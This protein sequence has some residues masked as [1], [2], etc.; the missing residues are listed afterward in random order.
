[1]P[2][3][4]KLLSDGEVVAE[5]AKQHW[6]ALR[7]E[8]LYTIGWLL[9][10]VILIPWLDIEFDGWLASIVT[11]AWLVAVG[12][13][14]ARWYGTDLVVT[15][16]R[17]VYR[18]GVLTKS[19][20]EVEIDQIQ[21]AGYR[22]SGL[23]RIV[24]A[25]DL[26]LDAP[27]SGGKSVISDLPHPQHLAGAVTTALGDRPAPGSQSPLPGEQRESAV[28]RRP[29]SM[30]GRG[31][32][33]GERSLSR[34]EQLDIIARLHEEGKLSDEEFAREKTRILESE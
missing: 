6:I 18:T 26:L 22:Q 17:V 31:D 7:D 5:E 24:G 29:E 9:L 34:A 33:P 30:A 23:Q 20:Y 15:N 2:Y 11:I 3:P 8:L 32:Q 10:M 28:R 21:D 1:M 25:G 14:V 13:G 27:A 16:K 19:G 12:I 4:A